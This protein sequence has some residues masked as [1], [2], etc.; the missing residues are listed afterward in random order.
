MI[1]K[2]YELRNDAKTIFHKNGEVIEVE[3]WGIY[4]NG[5]YRGLA[6][7]LDAAKA[8]IDGITQGSLYRPPVN[9]TKVVRHPERD[10]FKSLMEKNGTER[11]RR[12]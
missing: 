3:A 11:E 9:R 7:T 12:E 2:G 5:D 4:R 6:K 1:Y 8:H 10:R